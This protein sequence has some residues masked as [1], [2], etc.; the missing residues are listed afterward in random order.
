MRNRVDEFFSD[1]L[2]ARLA[3]LAATDKATLANCSTRISVGDTERC[4]VV[5]DNKPTLVATGAESPTFQLRLGES[6]LALVMD[7][8]AGV[9][10]QLS[11]RLV[12]IDAETVALVGSVPG[13]L[14]AL[15]EDGDVTHEACFGPGGAD[16]N[17]P[18]CTVTCNLEELRKVQSGELDPMQLFMSGALKVEGDLQVAMALGGLLA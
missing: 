18:A 6:T 15:L 14:R 2:P 11:N 4:L 1:W 10:S 16:I 13:C 9:D 8:G 17:S 3:E 5:A 7:H 12:R